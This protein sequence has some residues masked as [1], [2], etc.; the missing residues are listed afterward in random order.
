[1]ATAGVAAFAVLHVLTYYAGWLLLGENAT[2]ER[3]AWRAGVYIAAYVVGGGAL[4]WLARRFPLTGE[5]GAAVVAGNL[6]AVLAA[7]ALFTV[8]RLAVWPY[9][10]PGD[11]V[12]WWSTAPGIASARAVFLTAARGLF[13]IFT[14]FVC[15]GHAS[16]YFARDRD[17]EVRRNRLHAELANARLQAVRVQLQPPLVFAAFHALAELMRTDVDAAE[18]LLLQVAALMRAMLRRVDAPLVPLRDEAA[19]LEALQAVARATAT[20]CTPAALSIPAEAEWALVPPAVLQ[21]L[22]EVAELLR[23]DGAGAAPVRLWATWSAAWLELRAA[24][25]CPAPD[26]ERAAVEELERMRAELAEL[27]GDE[28]SLTLVRRDGAAELRLQVPLLTALPHEARADHRPPD[29]A[30]RE[31]GALVRSGSAS[32]PARG[33]SG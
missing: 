31:T 14:L 21:R 13:P 5:R 16:V 19:A 9:T 22:V 24:T 4:V 11:P 29:A 12:D 15:A 6:L 8:M 10:N 7:V 2:I 26:G 17:A 25:P 32:A 23:G 27:Y 3:A 18:R 28:L 30:P 20:P 33:T 1:M